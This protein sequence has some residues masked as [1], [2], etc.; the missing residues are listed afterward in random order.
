MERF[1]T[2]LAWIFGVGSV[3]LVFLRIWAAIAYNDLD[4]MRDHIQ[5]KQRTFPIF[6]PICFTIICWVWIFTR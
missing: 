3:G 2:V 4:R 1:I 5:N 6:R